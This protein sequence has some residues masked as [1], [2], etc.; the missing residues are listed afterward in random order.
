MDEISA[1]LVRKA[2]DGLSIRQTYIAQNI[3]NASTEGY[4]PV[5]VDFEGDLR[6]AAASGASA[7]DAVEPQMSIAPSGAESSEMRLDLEL[8]KASQTAMRYGA[9]IN[10]LGRQMSLSMSVVRGGQ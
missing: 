2:L 7:I 8:A 10:L 5:S 3:A 9:L 6:A 1:L 4:L